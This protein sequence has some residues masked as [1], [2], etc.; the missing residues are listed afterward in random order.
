[1]LLPLCPSGF[2]HPTGY[3]TEGQVKL[4]VLYSVQDTTVVLFR[5]RLTYSKN[6]PRT[7]SQLSTEMGAS[8]SASEENMDPKDAPH[9]DHGL[10]RGG[11]NIVEL[12]TECMQCGECMGPLSSALVEELRVSLHS[13]SHADLA[14]VDSEV[15]ARLEQ[16]SHSA[17]MSL[18]KE[19]PAAGWCVGTQEVVRGF[20]APPQICP[21]CHLIVLCVKVTRASLSLSLCVCLCALP[22]KLHCYM[23]WPSM[24]WCVWCGIWFACLGQAKPQFDWTRMVKCQKRLLWRRDTIS[25]QNFLYSELA[26]LDN[27]YHYVICIKY[28]GAMVALYV[29]YTVATWVFC[30]NTNVHSAMCVLHVIILFTLDESP[31]QPHRCR[32]ALP[33]RDREARASSTSSLEGEWSTLTIRTKKRSDKTTVRLA[34]CSQGQLVKETLEQGS[35]ANM[36]AQLGDRGIGGGF[37]RDVMWCH[38]MSCDVI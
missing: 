17:R 18:V 33:C 1:M 26:L 3:A 35:F 36:K 21:Q 24:G 28:D 13:L 9:G 37:M 25:C 22:Q 5:D 6:A 20:T 4:E 29:P 12:L 19:A 31:W 2:S 8:Q 32:Q 14:K 27:W 38:L 7:T 15:G 16:G 30:T 23:F 34:S 10:K 11:S